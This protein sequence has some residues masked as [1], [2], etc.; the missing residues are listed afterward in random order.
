M[1]TRVNVSNEKFVEACLE[2]STIAE[3]A[4]KTGLAATT[5]QQRRVRL[6][7]SGTPLPEFTRGGGRKASKADLTA[8]NALIAAKTG[9]SVDEVKAAGEALVAAHAERTADEV[10]AVEGE[11]AK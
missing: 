10:A 1:A 11:V 6:R 4:A 2:S 8:I 5:V 9:K 7:N 3:V